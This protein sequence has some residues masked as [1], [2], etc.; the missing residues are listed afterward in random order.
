MRDGQ[1]ILQLKS[2]GGNYIGECVFR[3]SNKYVVEDILSED[4]ILAREEPCK[5]IARIELN[6]FNKNLTS[7]FTENDLRELMMTLFT[8]KKSFHISKC[9]QNTFLILL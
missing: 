8:D 5:E 4:T 3:G 1:R 2:N 7:D 9:S 6:G